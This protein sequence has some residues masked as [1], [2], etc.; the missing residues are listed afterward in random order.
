MCQTG[1]FKSQISDSV[2]QKMSIKDLASLHVFHFLSMILASSSD[3][4]QNHCGDPNS[5]L[6]ILKWL[7]WE[8]T[9]NLH[10]ALSKT[11]SLLGVPSISLLLA[12]NLVR[13]TF[14]IQ[15]SRCRNRIF[16]LISILGSGVWCVPSK[17]NGWESGRVNFPKEIRKIGKRKREGETSE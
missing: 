2:A 10:T 9:S 13:F 15:R 17:C 4:T 7:H 1:L 6:V 14:L 16:T 12:L 11:D 3:S 5:H 8:Q